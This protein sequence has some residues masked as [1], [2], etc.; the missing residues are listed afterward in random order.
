M[1]LV[2]QRQL[3]GDCARWRTVG[4]FAVDDLDAVL[5]HSAELAG[6]LEPISMRMVRD[7]EHQQR[8]ATWSP[9]GWAVHHN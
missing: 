6:L 2:L 7:D 3:Q 4:R 1:T 9:A 5:R 8:V